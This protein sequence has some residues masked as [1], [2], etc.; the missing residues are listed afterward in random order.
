MTEPAVDSDAETALIDE[1]LDRF[2]S[3]HDVTG[4]DP[5]HFRGLRYDAG[6]AWVHFPEGR[7]GLG[8]RPSLQKEVEVRLH[9]AGGPRRRRPCSSASRW[10]GRPS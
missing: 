7:G 5:I 4:M 1:T 3:E 6:L 8:V 9:R 10:P 2:L